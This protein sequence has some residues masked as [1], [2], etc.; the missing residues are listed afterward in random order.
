M[1]TWAKRGLQ[2]ALVTGGL[3]MLGTGIASADEDVNPD[4]P[5]SPLDG[6]VRVPVHLDNNALGTP[7][8][9]RYL[10]SLDKELR[11]SVKELTH[12]VPM[13][14]PATEAIAPV[15]DTAKTAAAPVAG[16]AADKANP[17][18]DGVSAQAKPLTDKTTPLANEIN[19]V[20]GKANIPPVPALPTPTVPHVDNTFEGNRID[21]DVIA[22]VDISGNAIGLLGKARVRERLVAVLRRR[23]VRPDRRLLR[24]PRRQRGRPRLGTARADHRQ[25]DLRPRQGR[26]HQHRDAGHRGDE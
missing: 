17:T 1:Q 14:H 22:P 10:P 25:R 8:G 15:V 4:R 2:T 11:V 20:T 26:R 7:L 5:A 9:Q 19:A 3:L 23:R 16:S 21:G 13:A 18:L 6:S 24:V 12:A